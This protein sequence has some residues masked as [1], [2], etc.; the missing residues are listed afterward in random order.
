MHVPPWA[1]TE[2]THLAPCQA[3]GSYTEADASTAVKALCD[4]LG[5]L[6]AQQVVHRNLKP[7]NLLC[8]GH[9]LKI[10]DVGLARVVSRGDMM[11]TTCGTPGYV[12]P[13]ILENRGYDSGAVDMWSVGV[14]LYILLCGFPPFYEEELPALF[15]Q[16]LHARYDFPFPWWDEFSQESKDLVRKLLELSPSRRLTASQAR[17]GLGSIVGC[18]SHD[19][20]RVA[21]PSSRQVLSHPWHRAS[22]ATP[23]PETVKSLKKFNAARK[24]KRAAL[25]VVAQEKLAQSA[26]E[27]GFTP[28]APS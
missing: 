8:E 19:T 18:G 28:A 4:A 12:A 20:E 15:E 5:Y 13:E 16:I 23:L 6:H 22:K 17:D 10:A 25:G 11:K 3:R 1:V 27:S 9:T 21:N 26:S 2:L 24:L 7:E 14:I